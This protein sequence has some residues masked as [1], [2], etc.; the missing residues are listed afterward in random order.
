MTNIAEVQQTAEFDPEKTMFRIENYIANPPE[1]SRI[2]TVTPEIAERIL[3]KYNTANRS[4]KQQNI[5]KFAAHMEVGTWMLTGDTIKFSDRGFLR[6]GQNRLMA[7][8]RAG[9]SFRSHFVFGIPD[10]AFMYIDRNAVRD[11]GDVLAIA[12]FSNSKRLSAAVRWAYLIDNGRAKQRD[13][14]EPSHVLHLLRTKYGAVERFLPQAAAIYQRGGHPIGLVA[15]CLYLFT[16]KN[17]KLATEFATGWASN[18]QQLRFKPIRLMVERIERLKTVSS[19]RV[20]D[21]VRAALLVIAWNW[22]VA[23]KAG[24]LKAMDWSIDDEFPAIEG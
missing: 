23:R 19:G 2:F 12:G 22:F 4:R 7:C 20:H 3:D 6:D 17:E 8:I 16:L 10:G 9:V 14:L 18:A 13:T 11:P 21:V 5:A 1:N 15:A 24:N